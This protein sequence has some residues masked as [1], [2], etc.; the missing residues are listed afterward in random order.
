MYK[1]PE[2]VLM[3][4]LAN[5]NV[6]IDFVIHV[7]NQSTIHL[8]KLAVRREIYR[9]IPPVLQFFYTLNVIILFNL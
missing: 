9:I 1:V 6:W 8:K 7:F 5:V 3:I 4:Y 2:R